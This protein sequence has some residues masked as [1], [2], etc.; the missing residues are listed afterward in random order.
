MTLPNGRT[1]DTVELGYSQGDNYPALKIPAGHVFLMGDNRDRSADSR[2]PA[3]AGGG[4]GF[5]PADNV[6]GRALVTFFSTDGS[7]IWFEPWTWWHATRWDRI[8]EG[9][10]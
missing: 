2:F 9:F 10:R 7:A 4:I 6:E 3:V 8:G 5:V 1:Y